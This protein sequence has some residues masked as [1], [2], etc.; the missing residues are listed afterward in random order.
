[1][2]FLLPLRTPD[3]GVGWRMGQ[4]YGASFVNQIASHLAFGGIMAC[5]GA[6]LSG[7]L[8]FSSYC[9]AGW[10]SILSQ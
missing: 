9:W 1:M 7:S 3:D 6:E 2:G 4:N 10:V 8:C 5:F